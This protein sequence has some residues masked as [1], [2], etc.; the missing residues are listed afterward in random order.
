M[1]TVTVYLNTRFNPVNLPYDPSVLAAAAEE[2]LN[3]PS[4]DIN[5]NYFLSS[6]SVSGAKVAGSFFE[7]IKYADYARV[8]DFYYFVTSITMTSP[9]VALL[10]LVPDYF[11][12]ARAVG[13]LH[14]LGGV[15][16][17]WRVPESMDTFGAFTED[18]ELL[19]PQEPLQLVTNNMIYSYA[20]TTSAISDDVYVETTIDLGN[21]KKEFK[22]DSSAPAGWVFDGESY[23]TTMTD[24]LNPDQAVTVP[25]VP[26]HFDYTAYKVLNKELPIRGSSIY[27]YNKVYPTVGLTQSLGVTNAILKIY[28][29]PIYYA[30]VSLADDDGFIKTMLG[31]DRTESSQLKFDYATVKNKRALYGAYNTFGLLTTSGSKLEA[32]PEMLVGGDATCPKVR[33]VVD[34]RPDGGP[35]FR[36]EYYSG[37]ATD[38]GFW[39]NAI[40]G[41]DWINVPI[42]SDRESGN[43]KNV[44]QLTSDLYQQKM[45]VHYQNYSRTLGAVNNVLGA[46]IDLATSIAGGALNINQAN[47]GSMNP[48]SVYN[49][50]IQTQAN[51]VGSLGKSLIGVASTVGQ[52]IEA[53]NIFNISKNI[54][55]ANFG[56]Q[57]SIVSPTIEFVPNNNIVRDL[58]GNGV[59]P[60]R[61]RYTSNDLKRVDRLLTMFGY[62]TVQPF[63]FDMLTHHTDFEYISLSG[64]QL[65]GDKLP[66]WWSNGIITQLNTGFRLW[67]VKP[68]V[69]YFD[70]GLSYEITDKE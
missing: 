2:T 21:L 8:G 59:I 45:N 40:K 35:Y 29:L 3:L 46:G 37:D 15:T 33:M 18:D 43:Y 11:T 34:P 61:Y 4:I 47:A 55:L 26:A 52:N 17:R 63:T 58:W 68:D 14:S 16:K 22:E 1:Y 39:M 42:L 57:H 24:P 66:M 70:S 19:M 13:A 10:G 23:G 27:K 41:S 6:I 30:P 67:H 69:K 25:F 49:S 64:V 54:E 65:Y 9:D 32:N 5:Q 38:S 31:S 51:A 60:Y 56:V 53:N 20:P 36:F 28:Q 62:A 44:M 7:K 50:N 12:S 48:Q